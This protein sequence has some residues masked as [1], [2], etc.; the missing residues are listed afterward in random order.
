MKIQKGFIQSLSE[1]MNKSLFAKCNGSQIRSNWPPE[2]GI[3]YGN[4]E[5]YSSSNV[6]GSWWSV[7]FINI[8]ISIKYYRIKSCNFEAGPDKAQP[9]SWRLLGKTLNNEYTKIDEEINRIEMKHANAHKFY[10]IKSKEKFSGFKIELIESFASTY[11]NV[12]TF[13]E[14]DIYEN[15]LKCSSRI[16]REPKTFIYQIVFLISIS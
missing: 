16:S 8:I 9:K 7:D 3:T 13:A 2:A 14:F 10:P 12:L 5:R 6:P 15:L 1:K 4:Y 11:P